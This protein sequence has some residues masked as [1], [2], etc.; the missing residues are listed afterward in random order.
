MIS[1]RRIDSGPR[2]SAIWLYGVHRKKHD[3]LET[4]VH[5]YNYLTLL[6]SMSNMLRATP[7]T[8]TIA[9]RSCLYSF[10]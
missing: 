5:A 2:F 4:V 1:R 3:G 10:M 7:L 8:S 9:S 6:P